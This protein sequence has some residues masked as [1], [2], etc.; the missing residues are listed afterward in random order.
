MSQ[1]KEERKQRLLQVAEDLFVRYGYRKTSVD[2]IVREASVAKGTFYLHFKSKEALLTELLLQCQRE[3]GEAFLAKF[4]QA[5]TPTEKLRMMMHF[6]IE[7]ID[8]KPILARLMLDEPEYKVFQEAIQHPDH[9]G[10]EA[11]MFELLQGVL[12]EGIE[13]GELRPDLDL[14]AVPGIIGS[15]KLLHPYLEILT[16]GQ[17]E[18]SRFISA[19]IETILRG[20]RPDPNDVPNQSHT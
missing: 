13:T 12:R 20:L 14:Q 2:D 16:G 10:Q 1:K 17:Y 4:S 11:V 8:Q 3:A 19:Y 5:T 18:P 7:I 6:S 9:Q 15:I